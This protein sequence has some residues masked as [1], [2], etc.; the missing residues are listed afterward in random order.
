[1]AVPTAMGI[2]PPTI[3]EEKIL[4]F[5]NVKAIDFPFKIFFKRVFEAHLLKGI[6]NGFSKNKK[7]NH[8]FFTFLK[9]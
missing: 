4:Y 1:M 8:F 2:F 7:S 9:I 3:A 6:D 5:L